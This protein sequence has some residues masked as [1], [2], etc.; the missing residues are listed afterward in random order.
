MA[1]EWAIGAGLLFSAI[2]IL[3]TLCV[4]K[5][6]RTLIP[7]GVAVAV[8]KSPAFTPWRYVLIFFTDCGP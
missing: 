1:M 5:K 8:G 2:T 3:R 4:G 6:W 7:G